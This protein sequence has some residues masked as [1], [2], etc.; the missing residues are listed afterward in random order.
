MTQSILH[1]VTTSVTPNVINSPKSHMLFLLPQPQSST[2]THDWCLAHLGVLWDGDRRVEGVVS[3][4]TS[5]ERDGDG[6]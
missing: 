5:G 1:G 3:R 4:E 2:N 6:R